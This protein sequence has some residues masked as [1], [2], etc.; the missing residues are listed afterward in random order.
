MSLFCSSS[1]APGQ[2]RRERL[3]AL[4]LLSDGT[5]DSYC[6][7]VAARCHAPELLLTFF[8]T[9]I[10][11][12]DTGGDD[13]ERGLILDV[14][15]RMLH[16]G[17]SVAPL[18]LVSRVGLLSWIHSL[19]EGRPSL[20]I[21]IRIKIVK[22]LHAAVKAANTHEILL[23]SDP[24]DFML[25]LTGASSSVIWLCTDFSKLTPTSL[26]QTNMDKIPLVESGC[27]CLRMM[28]LVADQA[29]SKGVE[30][31]DALISCS[32]IS[33]KSS[34]AMLSCVTLNWETKAN[35]HLPMLIE[36]I[37]LLPF[38][39]LEEDTDE[40]RFAWC[41]QVLLIVLRNNC[42]EVMHQLLKR[43][44]LILKVSQS[45]PPLSCSLLET[46]LRCRQDIIVNNEGE[47]SWI[48]CLS[49]LSR[50]TS[51]IEVKQTIA[52]IAQH[53]VAHHTAIL[54]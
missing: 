13:I 48:Q 53:L 34:M 11:R 8:D 52:E 25:K 40:E 33:L 12:G 5:V 46:M 15:I 20:S 28:S 21:P 49:L 29:R 38:G 39:I 45:M 37:C 14:L 19:V 41:S 51:K 26:Q 32:G 3:W 9:S 23:E 1:E 54:S 16:F 30:A 27:E 43:I 35:S 24:K 42:H 50:N 22:L 47:D 17:S 36:A 6:Y 7:K 18:H 44:L 4:Q 31:T 2:A 10:T